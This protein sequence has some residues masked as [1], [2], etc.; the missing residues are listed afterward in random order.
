M[1]ITRNQIEYILCKLLGSGEPRQTLGDYFFRIAYKGTLDPEFHVQSIHTLYKYS[2]Q[3]YVV[4]TL[5][6]LEQ[7]Y[8]D[9]L[10]G[11]ELYSKIYSE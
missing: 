9:I 10:S 8:K 7:L 5:D 6:Q 1:T 4:Y 2:E 3:G 11:K